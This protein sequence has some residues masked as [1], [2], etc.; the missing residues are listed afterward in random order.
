MS[1]PADARENIVAERESGITMAAI[2]EGLTADDVPTA[3]GG[4]WYP[5]TL[6]AV[7]TSSELD[8]A[9]WS[10]ATPPVGD[11]SCSTTDRQGPRSASDCG[12]WRRYEAARA[13]A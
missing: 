7:L 6:K 8:S 12:A 11:V 2:A 4:K 1:L 5:S 13:L 9:A 10:G 3:R